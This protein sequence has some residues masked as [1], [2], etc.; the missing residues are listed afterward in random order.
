MT[1]HAH[2][3]M[4]ASVQVGGRI[5]G[6]CSKCGHERDWP[7]YAPTQY[8]SYGSPGSRVFVH[9]APR[10]LLPYDFG[11]TAWGAQ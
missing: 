4:L 3:Y 7:A 9:P 11:Q 2:R 8:E 6:R 1:D 10:E 5:A